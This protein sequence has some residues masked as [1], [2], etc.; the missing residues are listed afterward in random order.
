MA[1]T[2]T[3]STE[4]LTTVEDAAGNWQFE[5][6]RVLEDQKLVGNF[7]ATKRFVF[8]GTDA[9]NVAILTLTIFF[10]GQ[11]P[12]EN[13][14]LQ[15]DHDFNVGTEIGSVSAASAAFASYIGKHFSRVGDILR[16][17]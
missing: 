10:L 16:I 6:G 9:Q 7:A 1:L 17:R 8:K 5:G 11:Q 15:G 4:A 12:P 14:T 2:L 13:I 3:L